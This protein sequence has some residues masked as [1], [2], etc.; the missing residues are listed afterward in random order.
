MLPQPK[1]RGRPPTDRRQIIDGI[2]YVLKGGIPWRLMP[3]DLPPWQ[4]AFHVFR[5]W[6]LDHT[7]SAMNDALRTCVRL[8]EGRNPEPSAA[9]LDSQSVKSDGHGGDVGYDAGKRIK[10][11][12]RHLLVFE[13]E[14]SELR[15]VHRSLRLAIHACGHEIDLPA[16][17]R[18]TLALLAVR[19]TEAGAR[20]AAGRAPSDVLSR[21]GNRQASRIV[22]LQ[23]FSVGRQD[24]LQV[25]TRIL[26]R[27]QE[28]RSS[29]QGSAVL[30]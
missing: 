2:L 12:K 29:R 17:A 4:T 19:M 14:V 27:R 25:V 28:Y 11:R 26:A 20:S 15:D 9:I 18:E 22:E 7:W 23:S 16:L 13:V 21:T 24:A 10:G 6:T 8:E 1:K 5:K 3:S 30:E